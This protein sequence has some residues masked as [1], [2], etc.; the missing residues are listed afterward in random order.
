M[1][2]KIKFAHISGYNISQKKRK[3]FILVIG[4]ILLQSFKIGIKIFSLTFTPIFQNWDKL[5]PLSF[6]PIFRNWDKLHNI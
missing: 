5:F 6:T 3:Y 2:I 4:K 1:I